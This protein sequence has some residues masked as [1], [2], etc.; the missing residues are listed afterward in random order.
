M[1]TEYRDRK[2]C[3]RCYRPMK[4][5]MCKYVET[6]NTKTKFIILMHPKEFQKTKNNTGRLTH[7]ALKNSE[8]LIAEGFAS[9]RRVNELI[10]DSANWC[11]VLYPSDT[12]IILNEQK[13]AQNNKCNVIFIIDA[14]WACSKK[15]LRL[16]PNLDALKKI[17]FIHT[18]TSQYQI[19]AQPETHCLSTIESTLC[20]LELLNE[21]GAESIA[22]KALEDFL[23]PFKAMV[24]YQLECVKSE[25]RMIRFKEHSAKYV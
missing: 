10:A 4:S 13:M 22:Q 5:C 19:K 7:L 15:M 11:Y 20:V 9:N 1:G 14:T 12:S 25:G 24:Q 8:L 21:Q 23:N 2:K 3:Y 18:K 17:S 16:S 6:V